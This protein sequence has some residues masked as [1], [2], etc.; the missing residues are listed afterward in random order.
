MMIGIIVI[1]VK[2][3]SCQ[4]S[5]YEEI[6]KKA[7]TRAVEYPGFQHEWMVLLGDDDDDDCD[8]DNDNDNNG[9]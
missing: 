3:R 9:N 8:D 1:I 7:E 6:L 5:Q 4:V 2:I